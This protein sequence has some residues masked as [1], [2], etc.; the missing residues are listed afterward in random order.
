MARLT[1][2]EGDGRKTASSPPPAVKRLGR[3]S[4][5][6]VHNLQC[7]VGCCSYP[8]LSVSCWWCG[9]VEEEAMCVRVRCVP[10]MCA[11]DVCSGSCYKVEC[12]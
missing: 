4:P 1:S 10:R 8:R 12:G 5:D 2:D 11:P 6:D 3:N 9:I 7:V